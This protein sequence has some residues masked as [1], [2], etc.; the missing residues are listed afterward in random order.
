MTLTFAD[1]GRFHARFD[2]ELLQTWE[3][4]DPA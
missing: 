4:A 1:G 3:P 2:L